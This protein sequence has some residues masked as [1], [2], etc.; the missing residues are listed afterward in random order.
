MPA[1]F[2]IPGLAGSELSEGSPQGVLLWVSYTQIALGQIGKTRLAANGVDPGPPDGR[3][4]FSGLPL[5]TY[6]SPLEKSLKASPDLAGYQVIPW[7][8]DWRKSVR[9]AGERLAGDIRS[10]ASAAD[11]ATIVAHSLGG[12]VARWAWSEL[13][14]SAETHLVRRIIT[15][16]TPHLG[17]YAPVTLFSLAQEIATQI[18][19]LSGLVRGVA[20]GGGGAGLLP[21]WSL[22][23]VSALCGTWPALYECF[24]MLDTPGGD[25]D[26]HRG[27]LYNAELWPAGR[28]VDQTW[29]DYARL[30]FQ[31][32]LRSPVSLP[33]AGVLT[34]VAGWGSPTPQNL[35]VPF[36]LGQSA[37][38][39]QTLLGDSMVPTSSALIASA[40]QYQV[41]VRHAD[42][43][44]APAVL[45][46]LAGWILENGPPP[47]PPIDPVVLPGG[48]RPINSGPPWP[49]EDSLRVTG[50][51]RI[52]GG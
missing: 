18:V 7:G 11:P 15:L 4:L 50:Y 49:G 33:P 10:L 14:V 27:R 37:A 45:D 42:L 22:E 30:V 44:V 31:A 16:G 6:Y 38:L 43:T 48:I 19:I 20:T 26:P 9:A 41:S 21:Q 28:G 5:G 51:T 35:V 24:P 39:G 12:L 8:Y 1:I 25:S 23:K 47:P 32:W 2:C 29:L 46:Q 52:A 40:R 3:E 34:T 36:G 17:C 13:V